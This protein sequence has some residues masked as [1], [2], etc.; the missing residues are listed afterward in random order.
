MRS[1]HQPDL[2]AFGDYDGV[3]QKVGDMQVRPPVRHYFRIL[4]YVQ[5]IRNTK[6]CL[7][8]LFMTL[9]IEFQIK[10]W[11]PENPER[12]AM[13]ALIIAVSVLFT[14]W[15]VEYAVLVYG[16]DPAELFETKDEELAIARN[17]GELVLGAAPAIR[18]TGQDIET[19]LGALFSMPDSTTT[20]AKG[21]N[22][23]GSSP[24]STTT[25][26]PLGGRVHS[27]S[28]LASIN[29]VFPRALHLPNG[30]PGRQPAPGTVRPGLINFMSGG[31][32]NKKI[33][34]E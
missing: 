34:R 30:P 22:S 17:I 11:F 2:A 16:G 7:F 9:C 25:P 21:T 28:P 23:N 31:G 3:L 10:A 8:A 27:V 13:F 29:D 33:N 1:N 12:Q 15:L 6:W 5:R 26:S 32:T 19:S 14:V 24:S 18:H 20:T 4:Y